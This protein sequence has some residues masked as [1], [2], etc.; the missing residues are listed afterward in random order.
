[1]DRD[2]F[3]RVSRIPPWQRLG[4]AVQTVGGNEMAVAF[5]MDFAGGTTDDYDAVVEKM[6]LG[7]R[8]PAGALFH[9]AGVSDGVLRVCDVWESEEI[10]QRFAEG[11][12]GPLTQE[13]GLP[14]PEVRSFE[15]QQVRGSAT[16]SVAFVQVVSIP[17]ADAGVF[18]ALDEN[19]LGPG[20]EVPEACVFHVNGALGDGY[21]V[22][23]YWTSKAARDE[24]MASKVGPAAAALGI[25]TEP[26]IEELTVHNSLTQRA[27]AGV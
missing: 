25:E 2:P 1:M 18:R 21:A 7:G 12:I 22:L 23:D 24:F 5:I 20:G 15:A 16:G 6:D 4:G 11:K 26:V 3:D 19:V 9:A 13:V 17:G 8:L 14:R 27:T 10:F